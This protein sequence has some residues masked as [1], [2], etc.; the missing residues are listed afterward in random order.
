MKLLAIERNVL[1]AQAKTCIGLIM[2]GSTA[3]FI[4]PGCRKKDENLFRVRLWP[5]KRKL[6]KL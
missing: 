3:I 4:G 2:I 6:R 5:W 1:H